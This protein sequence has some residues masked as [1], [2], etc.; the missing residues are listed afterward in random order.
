VTRAQPHPRAESTDLQA[1]ALILI[2]RTYSEAV[3]MLGHTDPIAVRLWELIA[4]EERKRTC[5]QKLRI[6]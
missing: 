5:N 3:R 2:R 6:P 1:A 4:A